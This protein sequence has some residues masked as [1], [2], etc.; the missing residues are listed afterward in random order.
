MI[1]ILVIVFCKN[2]LLGK[3]KTRLAESIGDSNALKVHNLLR[4]KT[5]SVLKKLQCDVAVFHS[6]FIPSNTNW[7]FTKNQKIQNGKNLGDRMENAFRWAFNK[8]YKRICIIGSDLW[9]IEEK[10]FSEAFSALEK[11]DVVFGPAEDGGY[12]LLGLKKLNSSLFN[13]NSWGTSTVLM[14]S[15]KKIDF[16]KSIYYLPKLNDIDNEQDLN[17]HSEI[18]SLI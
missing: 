17:K 10:I 18:K 5:I 2:S 16:K 14:E 8:G 15:I 1:N 7:S 11:N 9:S 4:D 13:I 3:V 12:Y 6:D